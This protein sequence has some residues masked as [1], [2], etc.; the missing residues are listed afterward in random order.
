[1]FH[2]PN[3]VRSM[4]KR[5]PSK[6]NTH[7]RKDFNEMVCKECVTNLNAELSTEVSS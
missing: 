3:A 5:R 7:F 4:N 6:Y 2:I 1:M